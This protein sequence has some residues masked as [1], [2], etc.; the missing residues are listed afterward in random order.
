MNEVDFRRLQQIL[1]KPQKIVITTHR[2]PDGDAY[3]SSLGLYWFLKKCGHEVKVLSPND[4]PE[5]LKWLPGESEINLFEPEPVKGKEILSEAEIV[6]TL[7]FNAFHRL[8]ELMG[9]AMHTIDPVFVMIDHHQQPD[10]FAAFQFVDATMSSTSEMVYQFIEGLGHVE[11]IDQ[12]IASCL[13]TGI[14]TDTGSFR[15]PA[16]TSHT[17]RVVADLLERGAD[18]SEIY[19][20][21]HNVN[22]Y[23]RMQLLGRALDN[24]V[25]LDRFHTA[26][27]TLSQNELNRYNFQRGDTEGFVNYALSLK[28]V[29]FAAIFIEDKK[30]KIIKIS[31]RSVGDFSV[32]EFSRNHFNGGGHINAAGGRSELSL[33]DTVKKFVEIL[34][35]LKNELTLS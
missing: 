35:S 18:N 8:G 34:P 5:F 12:D 21:I 4:C 14:L 20:R 19:N 25:V 16:T 27:I 1:S 24:M 22:T 26:Y 2:N 9:G 7:D 32:N 29:M 30:Q 31:F 10:D 13:Y 11:F 15:F 17:H 3:G 28:N 33:K 23:N 6:F